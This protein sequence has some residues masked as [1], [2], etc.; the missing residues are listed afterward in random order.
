MA[1]RHKPMKFYT[2]QLNAE[3]IDHLRWVLSNDADMQQD[4]MDD[5][6]EKGQKPEAMLEDW[7]IFRDMK[8][9]ALKI[10]QMID[11]VYKPR[12]K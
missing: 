3:D 11:K 9:Q 8:S 12:R 6:P 7:V 1:K 10:I 4:R 5:P 2:L